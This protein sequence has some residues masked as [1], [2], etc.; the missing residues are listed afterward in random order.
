MRQDMKHVIIDRPRI[1]G[2]H[3][4]SRPKGSMRRWQRLLAED[5]PKSESTARRRLY[6]WDCKQ[7]NEHLSPLRRWLRSNCGRPWSEVYSE[8][9]A[10]LSVRNATSA[11]VRDH[12]ERYVLGTTQMINGVVCDSMGKPIRRGWHLFYVDPRDGTLR[13]GPKWKR[14]RG[15]AKERDY[16]KG[17]DEFHQYRVLNGFWYEV[18]LAP[19]P[20]HGNL[21]V[22]DVVLGQTITNRS[23]VGQ[24]YGRY[25]YAKCKRQ[26]GK[27]KIKRLGL[28][29]RPWVEKRSVRAAD[30][31]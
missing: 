8:I 10:G 13:E 23:Q 29:A 31:R 4:K 2:R 11:H 19:L 1:G 16:I 30:Q 6:G 5:Y 22:R 28:R 14:Q 3:K 12:A 20:V 27:E 26:L 25:V 17:Q 9:C 15:T 18:E 24:F 7:L 21:R